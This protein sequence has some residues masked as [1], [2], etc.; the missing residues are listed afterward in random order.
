MHADLE[1]GTR[2]GRFLVVRDIDGQRHAVAVGAV[3]ALGETEHGVLLLLS[4]GRLIH[5]P[6]PLEQMLHWLGT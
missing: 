2:V 5:V 3:S 4:G 1:E 6:Q